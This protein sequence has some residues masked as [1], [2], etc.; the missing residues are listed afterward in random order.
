LTVATCAATDTPGSS[1]SNGA[2]FDTNTLGTHTFT[3]QV[4]DSAT[5]SS[6]QSITYSVVPPAQAPAISG[7]S[8][9]TFAVGTPASVVISA[10]GYPLPTFT[11][12][13][14]LPA[15]VTFVDNGNGTATLAGT[16]TASGIFPITFIATNGVGS[17]AT[18]PFTLTVTAGT[19]VAGK[20][21]GVYNGTFKGNLT[22]SSGQTCIFVGGG[23][24]GNVT[25][26]G[27]SLQ[28]TNAIVS[29]NLQ[30]TGGTF[31]VGPGATIK[32]NFTVLELAK[33]TV[34][35]QVC[36]S[37]IAGN[38]SI[39]TSSIPVNIGSSSP[40]CAGN[41]ISGTLSVTANNAAVAIYN[42]TIAGSLLDVGN[43][44]PTQVFSNHI[45]DTLS[46]LAN[47]SITGGSNTAA[48][49]QGQC[50]KF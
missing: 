24:S 22:V 10:T 5:N 36:G 13:G 7:A 33:S 31:A 29:G 28:L 26:N 30:A 21:N 25:E 41:T 48:L 38:L 20:C 45:K 12:T 3:V 34:T 35:S 44:K 11:K 4:E 15:G 1:V 16:A 17:P 32:G 47:S 8:S 23:V 50:A 2:Q 27:G 43:L 14:T 49:K 18:L 40:S 19:P 9:A 6:Q 46:C 42:N 39:L 37:S